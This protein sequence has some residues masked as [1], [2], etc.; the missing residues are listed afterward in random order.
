LEVDRLSTTRKA[1]EI[2]RKVDEL[3]EDYNVRL[4][5]Y[6]KERAHS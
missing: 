2:N 4:A 3:E 5:A 1:T 6:L